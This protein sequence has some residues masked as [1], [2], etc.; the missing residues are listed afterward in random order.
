MTAVLD[1]LAIGTPNLTDGWELF[2]GVLGGTWV[3]GDD[4]PGYWW[5]QLRF[6]AGP[7]IETVTSQIGGEKPE[8]HSWPG[9]FPSS[10]QLH[11]HIAEILDNHHA[12]EEGHSEELVRRGRA[13]ALEYQAHGHHDEAQEWRNYANRLSEAAAVRSEVEDRLRTHFGNA[14]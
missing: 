14:D 3:Y 10:E 6:A 8:M 5:G 9:E 1:H 2:G 7:K 4:S 12:L 11:A 13:T